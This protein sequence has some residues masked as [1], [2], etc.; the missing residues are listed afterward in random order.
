MLLSRSFKLAVLGPAA[1]IGAVMLGGCDKQSGQDAQPQPS[2][3]DAPES[4]PAG[5][6]DRSQRGSPVPD[7]VL[8]DPAGKELRLS[9]LKGEP[10]LINLWAT[11]CRPCI[12]ELPLLNTLAK[13]R[14]GSLRVLTVSQDSQNLERVAPFLSERGFASLAPWLDPEN[15]LSFHYGTGTLP[16]TIYYD[17]EGREIWRFVGERDWTDAETADMLAEKISP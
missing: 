17:A 5:V 2:Q 11:W 6:I 7:F 13:D 16:T 10:V 9:S 1:V 12:T 4:V 15:D 3:T 14:A 8:K